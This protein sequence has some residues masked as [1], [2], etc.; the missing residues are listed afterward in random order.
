MDRVQVVNF[1]RGPIGYWGVK[2]DGFIRHEFPEKEPES[3]KRADRLAE[4]IRRRL[5]KG[6][7]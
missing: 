7:Q 1:R 2:V 6:E 3:R 4:G 5:E